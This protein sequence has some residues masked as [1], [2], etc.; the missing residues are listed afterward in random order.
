MLRY[1][2]LVLATQQD[3]LLFYPTN[4]NGRHSQGYHR[5]ASA[6]HNHMYLP[7]LITRTRV[8]YLPIEHPPTDRTRAVEEAEDR[9]G[10]EVTRRSREEAHRFHRT[11]RSSHPAPVPT[12]AQG[13]RNCAEQQRQDTAQGAPL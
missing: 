7:H 4:Q 10:R 11:S 8:Q 9:R 13:S 12:P 6:S 5:D 1:A 3:L 2:L